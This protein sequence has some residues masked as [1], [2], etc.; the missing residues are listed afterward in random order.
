M[1]GGGQTETHSYILAFWMWYWNDWILKLRGKEGHFGSLSSSL[2][3]VKWY[4][5][6]KPLLQSSPSWWLKKLWW[7][8][9]RRGNPYE[10]EIYI[11]APVHTFS[12]LPGKFCVAAP[13]VLTIS[14]F[15]RPLE[16]TGSWYYWKQTLSYC[17]LR[18]GA[19][20]HMSNLRGNIRPLLQNCSDVSSTTMVFWNNVTR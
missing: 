14:I 7:D 17:T 19:F 2:N 10:L 6:A 13:L 20:G 9:H 5:V 8:H 18:L 12:F 4:F 15:N 11:T 16:F 3:E 1:M